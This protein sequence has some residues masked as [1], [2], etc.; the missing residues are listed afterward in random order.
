M[1]QFCLIGKES[2]HFMGRLFPLPPSTRTA[3]NFTSLMIDRKRA[4]KQTEAD[5][6]KISGIMAFTSLKFFVLNTA[7]IF[8]CHHYRLKASDTKAKK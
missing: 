3:C 4:S 7:L 2:H 8:H 1:G 5:K 6:A